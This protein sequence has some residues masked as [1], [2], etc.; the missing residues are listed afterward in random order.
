MVPETFTR[1]RKGHSRVYTEHLTCSSCRISVYHLPPIARPTH[2]SRSRVPYSAASRK[3]KALFR[4][5]T[6]HALLSSTQTLNT[7]TR[8]TAP[9]S[10]TLI[11]AGKILRLLSLRSSRHRAVSDRRLILLTRRANFCAPRC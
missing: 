11:C 8:S 3:T 6:R 5:P 2:L 4:I 9:S 10:A 7:A 1:A